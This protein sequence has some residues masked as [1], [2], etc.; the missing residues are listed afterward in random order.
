MEHLAHHLRTVATRADVA[1]FQQWLSTCM[2][3][4]Q[5]GVTPSVEVCPHHPRLPLLQSIV[6]K[7]E[8]LQVPE[9]AL[10][11]MPPYPLALL[12]VRNYKEAT[13]RRRLIW[14]SIA[15]TALFLLTIPLS[16][17]AFTRNMPQEWSHWLFH[18]IVLVPIEWTWRWRHHI[19]K[20]IDQQLVEEIGQADDFLRALELAVKFDLRAGVPKKNVDDLLERLNALR[21]EEGYPGLSEEDLL[22][23]LPPGDNGQPA[24]R[25][26]AMDK[27]EVLRRHPPDEHHKV[28]TITA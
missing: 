11:E 9:R 22:P 28:D 5:I 27:E 26:P 10:E 2:L 20:Q 3:Y 13:T 15:L 14:R 12:A 19:A 1:L 24:H 7:G 8:H 23:P 25:P 16:V 21:S 6:W 4:V 18:L 17:H